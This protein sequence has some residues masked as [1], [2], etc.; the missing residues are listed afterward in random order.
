MSGIDCGRNTARL[1]TTRLPSKNETAM[2]HTM[3]NAAMKMRSR[4]H[5]SLA[6]RGERAGVRGDQ[7][8]RACDLLKIV[9]IST[10]IFLLFTLQVLAGTGPIPT[11]LIKR[12]TRTLDADLLMP[13]P[14]LIARVKSGANILLIDV[15]PA[16]DYQGLHIPGAMNIPLHFIKTKAYLKSSPFVLVDKGLDYHRLAPICRQLRK[17]GF[18]ARILEGGMS[19]WAARGGPMVGEPVRQMDYSR[20]SPVDFFQEKDY[21]RRIVCDVSAKRSPA[22]RRLMPYAVHLPLSGNAKKQAA[23][24]EK[25]KTAYASAAEETLLVVDR[26]GHGYRNVKRAFAHAGFK[27]VFYLSGGVKAYQNYLE[28][29]AQSWQ[30][31][32]KR[33]LRLNRCGSCGEK[34]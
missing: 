13:A 7:I 10:T 33:R 1:S 16:A 27:N 24:L 5:H 6:P 3:N 4:R 31:L 29:V 32:K 25:F 12:Q 28:G 8:E 17:M 23:R 9:C 20:I 21:A 34:E 26:D 19:A 15:R 22:S 2:S 30:P 11:N 18:H 14:T